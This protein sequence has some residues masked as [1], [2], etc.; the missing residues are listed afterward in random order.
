MLEAWLDY[1]RAT[2]ELKCEGLSPDQLRERAVPPSALSL[3]GLVRHMAEVETGW[4]RRGIA[5]EE[6]GPR[7]Y[8]EA[9]PDGDFNNVDDADPEEAFSAWRDACNRSR[10]ILAGI[11]SLDAHAA[12]QRD[13]VTF[14]VR[15]I[16]VHMI[17]EYARHNGHADLLRERLDGSVGD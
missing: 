9:D 1:H 8:S 12:R 14:S 10:A 6:V 17:E 13:G 15:W 4:F 2:L 11:A 3:L 5:G 16:V 7:F